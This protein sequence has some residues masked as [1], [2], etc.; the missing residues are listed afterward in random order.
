MMLIKIAVW[1]LEN[2]FIAFSRVIR[3]YT[4]DKEGRLMVWFV[5]PSTYCDVFGPP[6]Y[7]MVWFVRPSTY[8]L[9][10]GPST[11][12]MVWFVRPSTYCSVP[13]QTLAALTDPPPP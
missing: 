11:Y 2:S 1:Y 13:H 8:C 12:W 9:V 10:F 5:R 3:F 7:R 4:P 6:T